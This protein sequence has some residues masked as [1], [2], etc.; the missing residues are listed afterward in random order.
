MIPPCLVVETT[1]PVIQN[2][3]TYLHVA[4]TNNCATGVNTPLTLEV[5]NF[6][7]TVETRVLSI[8]SLTPNQARS[9]RVELSPQTYLVIQDGVNRGHLTF[10]YGDGY[11]CNQTP[12]FLYINVR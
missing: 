12:N 4:V 9:Q 1:P 8:G 10:C 5:K 11:L 6:H 7:T 2:R 3:G